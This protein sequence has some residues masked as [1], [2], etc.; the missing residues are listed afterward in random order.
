MFKLFCFSTRKNLH[1]VAK[2]ASPSKRSRLP[3]TSPKKDTHH[4]KYLNRWMYKLTHVHL[5]RWMCVPTH[6]RTWGLYCLKQERLLR[7][8]RDSRSRAPCNYGLTLY[9][10][11]YYI[12]HRQ[13]SNWP[14]L[15]FGVV[16]MLH[17]F[18]WSR[19]GWGSWVEQVRIKCMVEQRT[20]HVGRKFMV[21]PL[22]WLN[23]TLY[24]KARKR[25]SGCRI[26]SLMPIKVAGSDKDR[27]TQA[28][29]RLRK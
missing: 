26:Y 2:I 25:W 12:V 5:S 23:I 19:H 20:L 28:I 13:R 10:K 9:N 8:I 17:F 7:D 15:P 14:L 18:H 16:C 4:L 22:A 11:S 1:K 29:T 27:N 6:V 3:Y 24:C 21:E